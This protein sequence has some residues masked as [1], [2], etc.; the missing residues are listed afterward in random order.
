EEHNFFGSRTCVSL[1]WLASSHDW[2]L[3]AVRSSRFCHVFSG[4]RRSRPFRET[5]GVSSASGAPA[6][7]S[8]FLLCFVVVPL[9]EKNLTT[10]A[11]RRPPLYLHDCQS[12]SSTRLLGI[13]GATGGTLPRAPSSC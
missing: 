6:P 2:L 12:S 8:L 7:S 4:L 9:L 10:K 13:V 11:S 5:N 1:R 3:R